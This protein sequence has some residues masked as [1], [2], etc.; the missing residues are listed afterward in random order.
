[1]NKDHAVDYVQAVIDFEKDHGRKP[2]N[3]DNPLKSSIMTDDGVDYLAATQAY[4]RRLDKADA[5]VIH[6]GKR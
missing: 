5:D 6:V 4:L 3:T 1:M 2:E